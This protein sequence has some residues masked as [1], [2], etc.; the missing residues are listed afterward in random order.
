MKENEVINNKLIYNN[1]TP[2]LN[3]GIELIDI[4]PENLSLYLN[5]IG[6]H[7]FFVEY[8]KKYL[9]KSVGEKELKFYEFIYKNKINCEYM[10]KFHGVI[11][12]NSKQHEYIINYKKKCDIFFKEMVK[13]FNIK[14]DDIIVEKDVSFHK[15]F[16]DF[17][18]SKSEPNIIL[19]NS[20]ENLKQELIK[21]KKNCEKKFF[22]IFFWYIKWQ[23]EFISDKYII[24]Q[25]LEYET[26]SPSI[27]DIKIGN[28]KKISKE[29]GQVKKFKGAFES[30]GCRIMGISSNNLYF[31]SRY[32][33]KDLDENFFIN[34][35]ILFFDKNNNIINSVIN[36]LQNIIYF[37]QNS[38][39]QK[40]FFCS[41]LIFFDNS[42]KNKPPLVKLIDLDLTNNSKIN[43][44][45]KIL[46]IN[47]EGFIKCITNLIKTL[48]NINK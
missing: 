35:L 7:S 38:F 10:P 21:I 44:N 29:T 34:E 39:F 2:N 37:L 30:L 24:I 33:T 18:N 48:K 11:E 22:W 19:N 36:E 46:N 17:I 16:N 1:N 26:N 25:N 5:M 40:I 32:D 14:S 43:E 9:I 28:E 45:D 13:Y 3:E 41:L 8:T 31:K 20:F 47:N 23:K 6:G 15:R 4:N 42:D 27:L 12:K